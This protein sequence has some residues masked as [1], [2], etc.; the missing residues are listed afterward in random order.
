MYVLKMIISKLNIFYSY[1]QRQKIFTSPNIF[2]V[3][4]RTMPDQFCHNYQNTN[5]SKPHSW[6]L[7]L[8]LTLSLSHTQETKK[9]FEKNGGCWSMSWL[10]GPNWIDIAKSGHS[11][12]QTI[13][14]SIFSAIRAS[15]LY[16]RDLNNDIKLKNLWY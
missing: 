4:I 13:R 15:A 8:F 5:F 14:N 11:I 2:Q 1:F 10:C 7:I 12:Q 16:N 6:L 3:T 9:M